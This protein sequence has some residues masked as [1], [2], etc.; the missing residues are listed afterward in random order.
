MKGA[1][2]NGA[3]VES[4]DARVEFVEALPPGG[5]EKGVWIKRLEPLREHPG[6]WARV[7]VE[8]MTKLSH[9]RIASAVNKRRILLPPG[10]WRGA[11][12]SGVLYI[13][14]CGDATA[15]NG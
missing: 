9:I 2:A 15:R 4:Y 14:Y 5:M 12:R 10:M 13:C 6:V 1:R 11:I 3:G 8:G 7:S